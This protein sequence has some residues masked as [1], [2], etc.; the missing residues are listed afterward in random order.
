[1]AW[2]YPLWRYTRKLLDHRYSSHWCSQTKPEIKKSWGITGTPSY[3]R[4]VF[5]RRWQLRSIISRLNRIQYPRR[6]PLP[7]SRLSDS[8]KLWSR[9]A[10]QRIHNERV[11]LLLCQLFTFTEFTIAYISLDD[12]WVLPKWLDCRR[13]IPPFVSLFY[14]FQPFRTLLSRFSIMNNYCLLK[15]SFLSSFWLLYYTYHAVNLN[16]SII[17]LYFN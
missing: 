12:R 1:M 13:L 10:E 8:D 6:F 2:R 5:T 9:L 11:W 17:P 14:T 15:S 16:Q 3:P 7:A 4:F